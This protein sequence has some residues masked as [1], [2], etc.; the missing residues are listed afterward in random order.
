[1]KR[2]DRMCDH[3]KPESDI[4]PNNVINLIDE[5]DDDEIDD[6]EAIQ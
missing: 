3:V 1:M 2:Y 4:T 6:T 5:C